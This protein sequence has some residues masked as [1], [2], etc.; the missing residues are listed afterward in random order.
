MEF[1]LLLFTFT[2]NKKNWANI[3]AHSLLKKLD[4]LKLHLLK[5]TLGRTSKCTNLIAL[6]NWTPQFNLAALL[7]LQDENF[8]ESPFQVSQQVL[9]CVVPSP[10]YLVICDPHRHNLSATAK[11]QW[12]GLDNMKYRTYECMRC[13]RGHKNTNT[14]LLVSFV[15]V[16]QN[17]RKKR[18]SCSD[19]LKDLQIPLNID[20]SFTNTN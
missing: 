2:V 12:R 15:T 14:K 4:T 13:M 16:S 19:S 5:I 10:K 6:L 8:K 9:T 1:H 3:L 7:S 20:F 11:P 17:L 18:E